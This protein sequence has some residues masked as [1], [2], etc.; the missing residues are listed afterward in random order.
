MKKLVLA[1]LPALVLTS[2]AFAWVGGPFDNGVPGG[3]TTASNGT[4][5][6]VITGKNVSGIMIFGTSALS[7]GSGNT[8]T[9]SSNFNIFSGSISNTTTTNSGSGLGTSG[10]EGRAAIFANGVLI[11]AQSS[12]VIDLPARQISGIFDGSRLQSVQQINKD[13]TTTTTTITTT[14]TPGTVTDPNPPTDTNST[15]SSSTVSKVLTFNDVVNISGSFNGKIDTTFPQMA[16]SGSGTMK[17]SEPLGLLVI[18]LGIPDVVTSGSNT[19][20]VTTTS[21]IVPDIASEDVKIQVHGV[22]TSTITPTFNGS[23][24]VEQPSVTSAL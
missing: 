12:A 17:I 7:N 1:L 21:E 5:Q 4:W 13:I 20:V 19:S 14:S 18:P 6:G 8:T 23:V 24:Q 16:F 2:P 22:K 9:Q 3:Q 11:I 10:G 15:T